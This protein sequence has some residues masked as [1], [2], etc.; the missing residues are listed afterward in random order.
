MLST[1]VSATQFIPDP[2]DA[3]RYKGQP[4][5]PV[6]EQPELNPEAF[7]Y[8][9]YLE[10]RLRRAQ[11]VRDRSWPE[12]SRLTYLQAYQNREKIAMT[13]VEPIRQEG[14]VAVQSG[15]IESKMNILLSHINSL[16]LTAEVRAF[17]KN[18]QPL[19]ELGT[20]FTDILEVLAE[21]DGGDVAG[22]TEKKA[23]RQRELMKQGTVFIQDKWCT[24]YQTKKTLTATYKGEFDFKAWD[25][26]WTKVYEG[27]ERTLLYGPNVYLGDITQ[28]SMDDQPYVFTIETM[29]F[30]SAKGLYGKFTNWKYVKPGTPPSPAVVAGGIGGRTI[31]DGRI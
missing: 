1:F 6:D 29:S 27:P 23:L 17:L 21:H 13:Y 3:N 15:T 4:P 20:A 19:K 9:N 24:K 22:D 16:N 8:Q 2:L 31:F 12:F 28:F 10:T 25:S 18:N 7:E 11:E 14:D 30:D 5:A 26:A